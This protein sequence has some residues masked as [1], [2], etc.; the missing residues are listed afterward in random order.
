M[1]KIITYTFNEHTYYSSTVC[2]NGMGFLN[3]AMLDTSSKKFEEIVQKASDGFTWCD[4]QDNQKWVLE[5]VVQ[6][7]RG[8]YLIILT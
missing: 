5:L 6:Y 3:R 1:I 2:V 4:I 7:P 8:K